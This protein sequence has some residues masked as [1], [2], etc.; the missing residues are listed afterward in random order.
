MIDLQ[1]P[2]SRER[3]ASALPV[4]RWVDEVAAGGPY[5]S[6]DALVAAGERAA[7]RLSDAER[8]E[9]ATAHGSGERL[10]GP[11]NGLS[12]SQ[13]DG[14]AR[15]DEGLD[16]AIARG[17]EV[18]EQRFGRAFLIQEAGRSRQEILDELQRR[19]KNDPEQEAKEA[20]EQLRQIVALR[21]RA[22]F[23]ESWS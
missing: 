10:A 20:E 7:E 6:L 23:A 16:A 12:P 14:L 18:Y 17:D 1:D 2:G 3:L 11:G 8:D 21:L 22:L 4:P 13:Q 15:S 9:A 19:L 5:P